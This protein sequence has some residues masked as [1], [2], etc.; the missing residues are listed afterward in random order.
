MGNFQ[1]I[2]GH[3]NVI[4]FLQKSIEKNKVSHAYI[5]SGEKGCGKKKIADSFCL[6][7]ECEKGGIDGCMECHACKQVLAGTHP[8]VIYLSREKENSIGVE[9]VR[10]Q[11]NNDVQIK[12]YNDKYKI[13][14]IEDAHLL[15]VQAQN[16]LLKTIEEP[17]EYV[18]ILLLTSNSERLLPTIISRCVT[19]NLRPVNTDKIKNYLMQEFK[20]PDYK[21]AVCAA[22]SQGN[23]GRAIRL[24]KSDDFNELKDMALRLVKY[25]H[26]MEVHEMVEYIHLVQE[27][28]MDLSEY[29]DLL[30]VWYRD[31]LMFK[32]TTDANRLIFKEE[33][34][35]IKKQ[36]SHSSYGGIEAVIEAV[37]TAKSRLEARVNIDL[38]MEL[39]LSTMKEN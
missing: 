33:V 13:Y 35:E 24:A 34:T 14:I 9:E 17:P 2:I 3:G 31:V 36:A 25:V 37:K 19:L 26:D 21:A 12:P 1:N 6:A 4:E 28:K 38:T 15:T 27:K 11:I 32:T 20:I 30:L 29:L 22:F 10:S 39:L 16:A 5:I 7:L 18:I 8:D 23:V